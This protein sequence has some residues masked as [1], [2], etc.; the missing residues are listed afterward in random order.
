[1]SATVSRS[2]QF[3]ALTVAYAGDPKEISAVRADLRALLDGCPVGDEVILCASEL[4]ANAVRHSHSRL[5]GGYFT[6]RA[7]VSPG[8]FVRIEVE[9]GGGPWIEVGRDPDRGHGLDIIRALASDWGIDGDRY[10]RVVWA[11]LTWPGA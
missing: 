5:P 10:G 7:K 9:D 2:A 4:A 6:L 8:D 1:M 11:L 3:S